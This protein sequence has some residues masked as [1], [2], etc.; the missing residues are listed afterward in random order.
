MRKIRGEIPDSVKDDYIEKDADAKAKLNALKDELRKNH[1]D[2][3]IDY[4]AEFG[5]DGKLGNFKTS[6]GKDLAEVLMERM[7][8]NC[9]QEW[10]EYEEK[11]WQVREQISAWQ[12][13]KDRSERFIGREKLV[14]TFQNKL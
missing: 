5:A 11:S 8:A 4:T 12:F 14:K 1:G 9:E 3:I 10:L 13:I 2:R 6:D 7:K